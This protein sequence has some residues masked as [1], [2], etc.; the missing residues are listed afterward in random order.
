MKNKSKKIR[1]IYFKKLVACAVAILLLA[2]YSNK[3][4]AAEQPQKIHIATQPLSEALIDFSAVYNRIVIGLPQTLNAHISNEVK[5]TYLALDALKKMVEGT[6][7]EVQSNKGGGFIILEP[8]NIKAVDL[9]KLE[10]IADKKVDQNPVEEV[11]VF[12]RSRDNRP[13]ISQTSMMILDSIFLTKNDIENFD[14]ITKHIPNVFSANSEANVANINIRGIDNRGLVV[15][16]TAPVAFHHNNV[17]LL[18]TEIAV[19]SLFDLNSTK[20]LKGS[21]NTETGRASVAGSV[22]LESAPP[23]LDKKLASIE[24]TVGKFE[25]ETLQGMINLPTSNTHSFRLSSHYNYHKGYVETWK[26]YRIVDNSAVVPELHYPNYDDL[27][28]TNNRTSPNT[29]IEDYE[30]ADE[31]AWRLSSLWRPK[32]DFLWLIS[33]ESHTQNNSGNAFLDP[34]LVNRHGRAAVVD[35]PGRINAKFQI[36]SSYLHYN[37]NQINYDH[38]L[39]WTDLNYSSQEDSDLGR[40]G[41]KREF[42]INYR[43]SEKINY[44]F[45]VYN[46]KDASRTKWLFGLYFED[47]LSKM[48]SELDGLVQDDNGQALTQNGNFLQTPKTTLQFLDFYGKLQYSLNKNLSFFSGGR[49]SKN[50]TTVED[51]QI[52]R[53]D[54]VNINLPGVPSL[55]SEIPDNLYISPNL[56]GGERFGGSRFGASPEQLCFVFSTLNTSQT[57]RKAT[58]EIGSK[59][60]KNKN[61]SS[62][63][64]VSSGHRPGALQSA[65]NI[66]AQKSINI[67]LESE[68]YLLNR[69]LYINTVLF[70]AKHKDMHVAGN[71]YADFDGDGIATDYLITDIQNNADATNQGIELTLSFE[72]ERGGRFDINA[73]F[74]DT[75]IDKYDIPDGIYFN[76]DPWNPPSE[77][78]FLASLGFRDL[79]GNRLTHAPAYT[80]NF[81][82]EHDFYTSKG[83]IT[84]LLQFFYSDDYYLDL[85]NR[86]DNLFLDQFTGIEYQVDNF[87]RQHDFNKIDFSLSWSNVNNNVGIKL[88]IE[89]ITGE[90]TRNRIAETFFSSSGFASTYSKPRTYGISFSLNM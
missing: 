85:Y 13:N 2:I 11:F 16:S 33:Y 50:R 49:Y 34:F 63:L 84:P 10:N 36:L 69:K 38:R 66:K 25:R 27:P 6:E 15:Q 45:E 19:L 48:D 17:Y 18:P 55:N 68:A 88:F 23:I 44:N 4:I 78:P 53:C 28:F 70:Q 65:E 9:K 60:Q 26:D 51:E 40:L 8:E 41:E 71:R 75:K 37:N 35:T 82:Y 46:S 72:R 81:S 20:I 43:N 39:G 47:L 22:Y 32:D 12:G 77:D 29:N 5:G 89:N 58:F 52:I 80:F 14:S 21:Q 64:K 31:H 1:T 57:W 30:N 61:L 83:R 73:S 56:L 54:G 3:S 67:E 90:T 59:V 7:L 79:S 62:T 86:E 87:S 24:V 42:R 74:I 76:G